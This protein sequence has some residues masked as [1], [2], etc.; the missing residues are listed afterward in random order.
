MGR[1]KAKQGHHA[2][3]GRKKRYRI[4]LDGGLHDR[5]RAMAKQ[6][7]PRYKQFIIAWDELKQL[8]GNGKLGQVEID[9]RNEMLINFLKTGEML[10][11]KYDRHLLN[12]KR[13]ATHERYRQR[14]EAV[15]YITV[16]NTLQTAIGKVSS[17][18]I[19]S[20]HRSMETIREIAVRHN[21]P[22]FPIP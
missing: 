3:E 21:L 19:V 20:A 5:L 9:R 17:Q 4:K 1:Q 6:D 14:M 22:T 8:N 13:E 12:P 16:S 10:L 15:F 11:A 18:G 2:T 7:K